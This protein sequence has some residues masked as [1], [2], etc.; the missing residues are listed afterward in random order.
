[1]EVAEANR[2]ICIHRIEDTLQCQVVKILKIR[3]SDLGLLGC[4]GASSW[5]LCIFSGKT[6]RV[7]KCVSILG[8]CLISDLTLLYN[9]FM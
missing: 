6:P 5:E 1:M 2:P 4:G 8:N 3:A 7:N 9:C